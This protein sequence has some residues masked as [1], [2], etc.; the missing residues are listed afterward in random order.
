MVE[1]GSR[2]AAEAA[3]G[4]LGTV[5]PG[6]EVGS[7]ADGVADWLAEDR[8]SAPHCPQKLALAWISLP[9][10]GQATREGRGV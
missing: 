3:L 6:V 8:R 4:T 5:A 2:A 7:S 9:Q 1:S 10:L